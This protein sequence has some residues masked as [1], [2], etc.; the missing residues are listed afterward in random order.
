M[1][2]RAN[3]HYILEAC[4]EE[5][6]GL[7][8]QRYAVGKNRELSFEEFIATLVRSACEI[9]VDT[10]LIQATEEL[11]ASLD[12]AFALCKGLIVEDKDD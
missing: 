8:H 11:Q 7:I 10:G 1:Y 9:A 2:L 5:Y 3:I 4:T 6:R 12:E